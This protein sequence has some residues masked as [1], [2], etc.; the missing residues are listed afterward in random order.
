MR[1]SGGIAF[2]EILIHL[3][4]GIAGLMVLTNTRF[5]RWCR[6]P[7]TWSVWL[8]VKP[9]GTT[10][11]S[12]KDSPSDATQTVNLNAEEHDRSY[13]YEDEKPARTARSLAACSLVCAVGWA[14]L[15]LRRR[16][17]PLDE[18][19]G[20]EAFVSAVVDETHPET[21][22][23]PVQPVDSAQGSAQQARPAAKPNRLSVCRAA[24]TRHRLRR[25]LLRRTVRIRAARTSSM[26]R[27]RMHPQP[28][29]TRCSVPQWRMAA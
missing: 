19:A 9:N 18:Y 23:M 12:V 17:L 27:H 21:T 2:V 25:V 11:T 15:P 28:A 1:V 22:Q 10:R 3:L 24:S 14:L 16:I 8:W 4:L 5:V 29:W 6:V 20:D 26:L 7:C 13:L